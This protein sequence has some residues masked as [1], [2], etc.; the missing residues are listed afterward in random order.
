MGQL[1]HFYLVTCPDLPYELESHGHTSY[2]RVCFKQVWISSLLKCEGFGC[3]AD[4]SKNFSA[5]D[6]VPFCMMKEVTDEI[7]LW[8][9]VAADVVYRDV[10]A[11][12]LPVD[13]CFD[14][15]MV[16][17]SAVCIDSSGD[18]QGRI[19]LSFPESNVLG[20]ELH[21]F[22]C[23][24]H[25]LII[26]F[27]LVWF[28]IFLTVEEEV[29]ENTGIFSESIFLQKPHFQSIWEKTGTGN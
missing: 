12:F 10:I 9:I 23:V 15:L 25:Y 3:S 28:C 26:S 1:V 11:P 19:C 14:T 17:E 6:S 29:E 7:L 18:W 5:L 27:H 13:F 20:L 2:K 16:A 4:C 24:Y 21:C 8:S 22:C